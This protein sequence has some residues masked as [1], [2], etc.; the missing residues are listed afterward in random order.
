MSSQFERLEKFPSL[1]DAVVDR[2]D[3][4]ILTGELPFGARLSEQSLAEGLGVS[5]GPLREALRRL[6]GRHLI[7]R[8]HN[9]GAR[10][11]TFSKED[12]SQLLVIREA[13]EGVAARC[14]AERMTS[15]EIA[16]LAALVTTRPQAP[17]KQ[18]T[19]AQYHQSLDHDFH[20]R[21][22]QGSRN[23]RLM[24]ILLKDT[25]YLLRIYRYRF[26]LVDT[27]SRAPQATAEHQAIFEAISRRDPEAAE[28]A[29]RRHLRN[30][31]AY[32]LL[33][34]DT[35]LESWENENPGPFA[36]RRNARQAGRPQA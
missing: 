15:D 8:V 6:E 34:F 1:V 35:L 33:N 20:Y 4:A 25:F 31:N 13:L 11:A 22:I 16:K 3:K 30:A 19:V 14:A 5:R 18:E 32:V 26:K 36:D 27:P 23:S 2:L 21:I 12:I 17:G 10:V 28:C 9:L 29:M 7:T 24:D